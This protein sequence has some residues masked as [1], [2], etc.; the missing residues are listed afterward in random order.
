MN[1][2]L[3]K[4]LEESC[5]KILKGRWTAMPSAAFHDAGIMSKVMPSAML[6][7]PS[8]KGISHDFSE[9][10]KEE[11]IILGCEVLLDAIVST[12]KKN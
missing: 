1:I 2:N 10:S 7:I 3:L 9:D 4:N 11:D 8:I 6:F 12:L 5:E